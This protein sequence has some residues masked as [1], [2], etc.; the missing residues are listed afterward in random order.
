LPDYYATVAGDLVAFCGQGGGRV[1]VDLGCGPGGVGLALLATLT[2]GTMLLIAPNAEA[3][4]H[5]LNAARE[6]GVSSRAVAVLGSAEAMPLPAASVD[7]VV[8][9]GS[10]FFWQ[11]R[12]QGLREIW[13]VLRPGERAMIGGGLGSGYPDWAR[14]EVIR[15]QREAQRREGGGS[16]AALP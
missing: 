9:R 6:R 3:L 5:A 8:S 10:F 2:E 16:G 7:A 13:R 4:Q 12:A 14:R 1:W 15:R 11:D